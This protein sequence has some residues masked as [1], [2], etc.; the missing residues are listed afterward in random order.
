VLRKLACLFVIAFGVSACASTKPTQPEN[1]CSIFKQNKSWYKAAKKSAKRW[2]GPI[3]VPM[4]IMYQ[5]SGFKANAKPSMRYFLG[6]IPIGR[7]SSAYGYSQALDST[8]KSY[9]KEAGSWFS[10]RDDFANAYDFIQWYMHKSYAKNGVSKWDGYAQYLN[11]HEGHGGYARGSYK[12]KGWLINVAKKVDARA[13]NYGAQLKGC[14]A[15]LNRGGF[16][17]LF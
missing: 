4:A 6:F 8:W 1:I 3:H 11:Y 10:D 14:Q 13:R 12:N 7:A 2:G 17:G 9:Q 16:F 15:D 5:E